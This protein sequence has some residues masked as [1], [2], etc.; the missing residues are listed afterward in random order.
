M[1]SGYLMRLT[2]LLMLLAFQEVMPHESWNLTDCDRCIA[3]IGK[4]HSSTERQGSDDVVTADSSTQRI[5]ARTSAVPL[6]NSPV[7]KGDFTQLRGAPALR[8]NGSAGRIIASTGGFRIVE[9]P[10]RRK[11]YRQ[12][13]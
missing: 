4:T 13:V 8:S 2:G 10:L 5:A 6:T 9:P 7:V 1:E 3:M 12:G 11:R